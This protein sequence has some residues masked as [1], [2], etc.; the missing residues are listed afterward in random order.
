[1][2]KPVYSYEDYIADCHYVLND[3]I[4]SIKIHFNIDLS[5]NNNLLYSFE[6][7]ADVISHNIKIKEEYDEW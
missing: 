5:Q 7:I 1:M 4:N 6:K 3:L 2:D